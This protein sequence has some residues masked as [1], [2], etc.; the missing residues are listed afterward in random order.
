MKKII[1]VIFGFTVI[2]LFITNS[3]Y[4]EW[5]ELFIII[6][7]LSAVSITFNLFSKK[8]IKYSYVLSSSAFIGF[9]FSWVFSIT[10]LVADHYL[11]PERIPDGRALTL[12]ETIMEFS[13]DLFVVSI[14]SV[15]SVIFISIVVT[16]IYSKFFK[17]ESLKTV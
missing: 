8:D 10:D 11:T 5:I 12:S 7:S 15:C 4:V 14:I 2:L 17:K 1:G 16:I 3:M 13:D 6:G 9:L